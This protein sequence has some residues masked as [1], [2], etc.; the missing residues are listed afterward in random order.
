MCG[1]QKVGCARQKIFCTQIPQQK[2]LYEF[3]LSTSFAGRKAFQEEGNSNL[4]VVN[5]KKTTSIL[6]HLPQNACYFT[7]AQG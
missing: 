2:F 5:D 4:T 3:S 6:Y 7:D 1:V